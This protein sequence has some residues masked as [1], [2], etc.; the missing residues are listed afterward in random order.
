MTVDRCLQVFLSINSFRKTRHW[1]IIGFWILTTL[2]VLQT[3]G[4]V[5][6]LAGVYTVAFLSVMFSF[7]VGNMLL[8]LRRADL[9]TPVHVKWR[10]VLLASFAVML[11]LIGNIVSRPRSL[12][13][14][15]IFGV[16]FIIPVQ[17]M[18]NRRKVLSIIVAI[19]SDVEDRDDKNKKLDQ[20]TKR[21][22]EKLELDDLFMEA[23][24]NAS[25]LMNADRATLWLIDHVNN[26]LW[27]KVALGIPTIRVPL[28]VG[29]VGWVTTHKK[30]LNIPDAY[31]DTR[32]NPAVD[33]KT[34]YIT[35]TILCMP[36]YNSS[37]TM[38]VYANYK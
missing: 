8:K 6:I 37:G 11:G 24:K 32:F 14:L 13:P 36:I 3:Q 38:L 35:D 23:M 9:P 26:E 5:E 29:I 16:C 22:A 1:I 25:D 15:L 19:T 34:G 21:I 10:I 17:I 30:T 27:S 4:N 2:L 20:A 12:S 28:G 18:L 33:K 7:T 31:K